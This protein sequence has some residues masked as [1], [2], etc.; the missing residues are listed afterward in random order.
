[1]T[2]LIDD[3]LPEQHSMCTT[4]AD[5]G[6]GREKSHRRSDNSP[7]RNRGSKNNKKTILY[8]VALIL[9]SDLK[10]NFRSQVCFSMGQSKYMFN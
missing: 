10:P 9:S 1:M 3:P 5:R 6:Q 7:S 4:N 2:S 8:E